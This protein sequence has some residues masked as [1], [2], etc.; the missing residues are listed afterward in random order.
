MRARCSHQCV[1]LQWTA[2]LRFIERAGQMK[3]EGGI[4]GRKLQEVAAC[5]AEQNTERDAAITAWRSYTVA[6]TSMMLRHHQLV[7]SMVTSS[8]ESWYTLFS[9]HDGKK[10]NCIGPTVYI[11]DT[12]RVIKNI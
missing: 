7:T 8:S 9:T 11:L 3:V 1:S 4:H 6:K 12:D 5:V 2:S 10:I